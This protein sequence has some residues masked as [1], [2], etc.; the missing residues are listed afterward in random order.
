MAESVGGAEVGSVGV[1]VV[2][3]A[4]MGG[5]RADLVVLW[6]LEDCGEGVEVDGVE[7]GWE[8]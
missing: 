1:L 3:V 2:A 5:P 7:E 6:V 4:V 8:W